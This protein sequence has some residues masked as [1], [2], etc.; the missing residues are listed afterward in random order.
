MWHKYYGNRQGA[1][2]GMP[3]RGGGNGGAMLA[4]GRGT[5]YNP[6]GAIAY[7]SIKILA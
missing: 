6:K 4:Y 5:A 3:E 2:L 1:V 7:T